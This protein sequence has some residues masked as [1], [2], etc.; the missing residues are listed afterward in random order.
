MLLR[1]SFESKVLAAFIAAAVVVAGVTVMGWKL[2][3]DAEEATHWVAHTHQV[4]GN[5]AHIRANTL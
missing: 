5:V 2:A 3:D 4:L 1:S